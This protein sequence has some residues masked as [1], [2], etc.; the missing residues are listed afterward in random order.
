MHLHLEV[1]RDICGKLA[2]DWL[3]RCQAFPGY[4]AV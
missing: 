4:P 2:P 3:S 1:V